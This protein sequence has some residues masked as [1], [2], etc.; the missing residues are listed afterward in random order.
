VRLYLAQVVMQGRESETAPNMIKNN[1]FN[2][3]FMKLLM[4]LTL[5]NGLCHLA[6]AETPRAAPSRTP[7]VGVSSSDVRQQYLRLYNENIQRDQQ[8]IQQDF[9]QRMQRERDQH[10]ANIRA[11]RAEKTEQERQIQLLDQQMAQARG[12]LNQFQTQIDTQNRQLDLRR[13][14]IAERKSEAEAAK[15]EVDLI[16][17]RVR[18]LGSDLGNLAV[19]PGPDSP[20]YRAKLREVTRARSDLD[21]QKRAVS[22]LDDAVLGEENIE[23]QIISQISNLQL[24]KDGRSR[25]FD[26]SAM[27]TNKEKARA[28]LLELQTAFEGLRAE[29]ARQRATREAG[30]N[31]SDIVEQAAN[32][33]L[34]KL[35]EQMKDDHLQS[36]LMFSD[37]GTLKDK[38]KFSDAELEHLKDKANTA[39]ENTVLG[40]Y[41]N[42]TIEEKVLKKF[43]ELKNRCEGSPAN[44]GENDGSRDAIPLP[45]VYN[46]P[47]TDP[48]TEDAN[49]T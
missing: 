26:F 47:Y 32:A 8:R 13:V 15:A 12:V 19:N 30:P 7:V 25:E 1:I 29:S 37:L 31:L 9:E 24:A 41:V 49:R 43:C 17:A 21:A 35:F 40:N 45:P 34:D 22:R 27:E 16:D 36:E 4:T 33:S 3:V 39:L 5:L 10:V 46:I 48:E 11:N 28:K 14:R 20:Q 2:E 23:R 18:T 38:F 44:F 42:K 6:Q